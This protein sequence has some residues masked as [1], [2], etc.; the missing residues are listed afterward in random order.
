[1]IPIFE[2]FHRIILTDIKPP[3]YYKLMK[4]KGEQITEWVLDELRSVLEPLSGGF[5]GRMCEYYRNGEYA[6][7]EKKILR[8]AHYYSTSWEFDVIYD[9]NKHTHGIENVKSEIAHGLAA[10]D[11]FDGFRYFAGS[12]RRL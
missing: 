3:V 5:Y 12:R 10:C 7:G 6:K 1:M 4:E 8:A 9:M 11:T 2:F